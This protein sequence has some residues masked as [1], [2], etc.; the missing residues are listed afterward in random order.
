MDAFV[1]VCVCTCACVDVG[2]LV[3]L[4]FKLERSKHRKQVNV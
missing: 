3:R 2:T 4:F 1:F